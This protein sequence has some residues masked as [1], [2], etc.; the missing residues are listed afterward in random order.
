MTLPTDPTRLRQV[1]AKSH[2]TA[3]CTGVEG[4]FSW[5]GAFLG[6]EVVPMTNSPGLSSTPPA[7]T[8]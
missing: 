1:L 8:R 2:D 7:V 4:A 6:D 3:H 5:T